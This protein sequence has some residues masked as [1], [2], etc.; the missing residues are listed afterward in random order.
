MGLYKVTRTQAQVVIGCGHDVTFEI[1][2]LKVY[3]NQVMFPVCPVCKKAYTIALCILRGSEAPAG[4]IERDTAIHTLHQ[5]VQALGLYRE[6]AK[7][8]EVLEAMH[9]LA[10]VDDVVEAP[11]AF[12][13]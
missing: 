12:R 8:E 1:S 7:P 5:R 10:K 9:P 6:G 2:D 11:S 3:K 13:K 4:V